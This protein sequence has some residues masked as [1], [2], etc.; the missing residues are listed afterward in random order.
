MLP[1]SLISVSALIGPEIATWPGT[2]P[3]MLCT[4]CSSTS[5]GLMV[6]MP[7]EYAAWIGP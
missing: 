7:A 6:W 5:P 1:L 3:L 4:A 2:P